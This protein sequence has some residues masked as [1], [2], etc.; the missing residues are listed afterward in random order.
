LSGGAAAYAPVKVRAVVRPKTVNFP[1]YDGF[2]FANGKVTEGVEQQGGYQLFAGEYELGD[3]DAEEPVPVQPANGVRPLKT[4]ELGLDVAG[5]A[6]VT[7]SGLPAGDSPQ[8][9]NAELEYA[10]PNG[11]ILTT[12]TR[13]P[14][15]PSKVL[16]GI[17][18]DTWTLSK[19]EL[20]FQVV[21]LDLAGK[22]V[23]GQQV[24][25][26]LYARTLFSHRKRLIGGFYGYES[27]AE[28]SKVDSACQ[29]RTDDKGRMF[30]AVKPPASGN[31]I[32]G[33]VARDGDGNPSYA[34]ASAWFAGS[35][36]WWFDQANDDRMD[37]IPERKRY[38]PGQTAQLQVRMPF[39][40]ATALVTVEREGVIDSFV[41]ALS[42]NAPVV[43]VPLKGD[44]APNV[45]VSV[46][47]VRGR[48]SEVQPTALV[49]LGKP[50]FKMGVAEISVGWR[51]H[52]LGVKVV[53]DKAVYKVREKAHVTVQVTQRA[54][55]KPVKSGEV[56]IAAV[57]EGLL[58]LMPNDS[59]KL[60]DAM[61]QAR[62]IE[63][64]TATASMQVVGKRH[65]GRKALVQGGGGG[66]QTAR[67]LFDTLLLWK[68]TLALDARGRASVDI[69]LNDSLTSFRIVAVADVGIGL[70]GSG[71]TSIRTT[72]DLM[73]LSGLP[74]LVR[75]GDRFDARFTVRNTSQRQS[76]VE[77]DGA[78]GN[79][80]L[81]ALRVS[82][83]PGEAREIGWDV[84]APYNVAQLRWD[85]TL[86]ELAG[87]ARTPAD[88]L[89]T[90]QKV[91]AAV[92]VRTV[93]ATLAQL[94]Q[95][96]N[97]PVKLPADAV[98]GRGGVRVA[99]AAKLADDQPGVREFMSL[100]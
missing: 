57:D 30:C 35:E 17:K 58:E 33:A 71:Q 1:D 75:E 39:R 86:A 63:V 10:D 45:F 31:I 77:L 28:V 97:L 84:T 19:D 88:R 96:L 20:K 51:A 25:V 54:G 12:S 73:L 98:P 60:L 32:I 2:T 13:V 42:G 3:A 68:A 7:L 72:Q 87:G 36:T 99:L 18:P 26:Q 49:D 53:A 24:D 50:A 93:Q 48:V 11:E 82:L 55:G 85:V 80:G 89:K 47:V 23:R 64:D 22:P 46:L 70:F 69:P 61:M 100:Y 21:A 37:V 78:I 94:D 95:P 4:Q 59:W 66:R 90:Q 67:E 62:G 16:L 40:Q 9:V 92:P 76:D 65:Y 5:S 38:E 41:Q 83:A 81:P 6:R 34:N 44:Y 74:P 79:Q 14:L 52:E 8:E 29:G 91:I 43:K 27:G 56:V 15:W